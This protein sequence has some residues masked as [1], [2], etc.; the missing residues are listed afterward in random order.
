MGNSAGLCAQNDGELSAD[1]ITSICNQYLSRQESLVTQLHSIVE[2]QKKALEALGG[3]SDDSE[4]DERAAAHDPS[5]DAVVNGFS[6]IIADAER[7]ERRGGRRHYVPP[8][9]DEQRVPDEVFDD[10]ERG[11][12]SVKPWLGAMA[13]PIGWTPN[14]AND[15]PPEVHLEL[16]HVYGYRSRCCRDNIAAFDSSHVIFPA[17]SVVVV[18]SVPKNQ[19]QF[20]R[21]HTDDVISM[22]YH[23]G[24]NIIATG[25]QG[26]DPMVCVWSPKDPSKPLATLKGFHKR[27]VTSLAFS[28]D[29]RKVL[30]VGLDDN[31]SLAV[32]D[33]QKGQ[34]EVTANGST[35]QILDC[36]YDTTTGSDGNSQFIVVGVKLISFWSQTGSRLDSKRAILGSKGEQQPFTCVSV[37]TD[38]VVVGTAG[39]QLYLFGQAKLRAVIN[40]H[41]GAINSMVLASVPGEEHALITGGADGRLNVWSA[42]TL[43]SKTPKKL[44]TVACRGAADAKNSGIRACVVPTGTFAAFV[45][46]DSSSILSV[47]LRKSSVETILAAHHGDPAANAAYG[48]MWALAVHPKNRVAATGAEDSTIR[49]WNLDL[50]KMTNCLS[51]DGQ[52]VCCAFNPSGSHLAVGLKDGRIATVAVANWT[53]SCE[54]RKANGRVACIAFSPDGAYLAAGTADKTV[55]IFN[56]NDGVLTPRCVVPGASSVVKHLDW[57][58][59]SKTIVC[60]TQAYEL[61]YVKPDGHLDPRSKDYRDTQFATSS[62]VLGWNVQ[63]IWPEGADGSDVNGCARS[64]SGKLLATGDDYGLVKVFNYPCIGSGLDKTG[65]LKRRPAAFAAMVR[66]VAFALSIIRH[67]FLVLPPPNTAI[68]LPLLIHLF[69]RRGSSGFMSE[70]SLCFPSSSFR[71]HVPSALPLSFRTHLRA[72][73][74]TSR[75]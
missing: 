64:T 57:A 41:T 75:T 35:A 43:N 52:P 46:T 8:G 48:E 27:A 53:K 47:D 44:Y 13:P 24:Q 65:K 29:G 31:H 23:A 22:T 51:L 74:S 25:Q 54:L 16:Q 10:D 38:N 18:H 73:L 5:H 9:E 7:A 70:V 20:F 67:P 69:S 17:A 72:T 49:L 55:I 4:S 26:K 50:R 28:E 59:D 58:E 60:D 11:F 32:Y 19:Q 71:R 45:G 56:V 12:A 63:G 1:Q 42:A 39:G 30:T 21:G 36:A 6:S 61:L 40:A 62:C 34:C 66:A 2:S 14:P 3:D 37:T 15:A 33:W 68:V